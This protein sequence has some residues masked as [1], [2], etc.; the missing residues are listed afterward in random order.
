MTPQFKLIYDSV[1]VNTNRPNLVA[2]TIQAI[3]F[4]TL[5]FHNRGKFQRDVR[6]AILTSTNGGALQYRFSIPQDKRIRE[7]LAVRPVDVMGCL[8]KNLPEL[9]ILQSPATRGRGYSWMAGNLTINVPYPAN[10]FSVLY[11]EFPLTGPDNMKSWIA[12]LYPHYI[13]DAATARVLTHREKS[14]ASFYLAKVGNQAMAGSHVYEL[15]NQNR[16]VEIDDF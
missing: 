15:L 8:G 16:E 2:E 12:D 6:E 3:Q 9:D 4:E 7:I 1:I 14:Q 10:T 5:F 11:L 13:S